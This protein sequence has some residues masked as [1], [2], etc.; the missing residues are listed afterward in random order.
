LNLGEID[1][2]REKKLMEFLSWKVFNMILTKK[3]V[4]KSSVCNLLSDE[5]IIRVTPE[6]IK[7]KYL[8]L[9]EF[10]LH[11]LPKNY[12]SL[13]L[14]AYRIVQLNNTDFF[15]KETFSDIDSDQWTLSTSHIT[16]KFKCIPPRL[17]PQCY[18]H[19]FNLPPHENDKKI[20]DNGLN[21]YVLM[22]NSVFN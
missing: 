15:V 13:K 9:K 12:P 16:P 14:D 20:W 21:S 4:Q 3:I 5:I 22:K 6:T 11:G 2:S 18:K 17:L 1:T 8:E 19:Y 7:Q 10:T